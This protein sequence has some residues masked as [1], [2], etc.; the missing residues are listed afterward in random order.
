MPQKDWWTVH[1][2]FDS[3]CV[4]VE[5]SREVEGTRYYVLKDGTLGVEVPLRRTGYTSRALALEMAR[6]LIQSRCESMIRKLV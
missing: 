5:Q 1:L 2:D 6:V 3:G 4:S